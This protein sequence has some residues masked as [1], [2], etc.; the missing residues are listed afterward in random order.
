[1][2]RRSPSRGNFDTSF[3]K[4]CAFFWKSQRRAAPLAPHTPLYCT[5]LCTHPRVPLSEK[6]P[7]DSGWEAKYNS[8]AH[9]ISFNVS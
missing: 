2:R 9:W 4:V 6:S 5:L 7:L 3:S 8:G 1:M